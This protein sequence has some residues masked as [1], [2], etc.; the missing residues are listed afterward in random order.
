MISRQNPHRLLSGN[1]Q[2]IILN[3][4]QK[5]ISTEEMMILV[6]KAQSNHFSHLDQDLRQ[7]MLDL[8]RDMDSRFEQVDKRFDR[9]Y[10]FMQWQTGIGVG[11]L[12]TIILK[13]FLG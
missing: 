5:Q 11:L 6:L 7:D 3:I 2:E 12:A 10:R 9:V 13:L 1:R 8:R 4:D